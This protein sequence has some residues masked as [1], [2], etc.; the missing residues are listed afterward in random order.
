MTK[1]IKTRFVQIGR[2]H[3]DKTPTVVNPSIIRG[4]TVLYGTVKEMNNICERGEAGENILRYGSFGTQNAFILKETLNEIEGGVS[5]MLFPTGLAAIAHVLISTLKIGDHILIS[6]SVYHPARILATKFLSQRGIEAEFYP[7]GHEEIARRLKPQT[8]MVY[9]DN[10]GSITFDIQDLPAIADLLQDRN[11]LLAVDNT[12]GAAGLYCPL[13]L[14][15]DISIIAITKYIAGHSDVMMGSVT[16]NIKASSNLEYDARI[17]GQI[18]SP[19]ECYLALRGLRTVAA[20]LT[21]HREHTHKV[22]EGIRHEP[23]IAQ[24]LYPELETD[25]GYKLF[26]RDFNGANGL[27]TLVFKPEI[28]QIQVNKFADSLKIFGLGA[29]WGG[30]ESLIMV[31]DEVGGWSGGHV[32]RLHIGLEDPEDL[33]VD[34]KQALNNMSS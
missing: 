27:I 18:A 24:I 13:R 30:Y 8:K 12:W 15:A 6:E 9:L 25:P 4:S 26:K 34:I 5:T 32:A 23:K 21:M 16:A 33:I 31:Y 17:L 10:P 7:G 2:G 14:G 22:I 28:T 20:R 3:K 1:N 11:T 29:S 19:D